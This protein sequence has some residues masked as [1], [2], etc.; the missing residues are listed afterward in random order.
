MQPIVVSSSSSSKT[1]TEEKDL[2]CN[3]CGVYLQRTFIEKSAS[4]GTRSSVQFCWTT[5]TLSTV[6]HISY[7][8]IEAMF[9]QIAVRKDDQDALRF[10]WYKNSGETIY[11]FK[12]LI[13]GATCL[14]SC[15]IY[16]LRKCAIDN[17]HLLPEA[18]KSIM[19]NFHM[20]DFLQTFKTTDEAIK[21]TTC[22]KETLK[23][24]IQLNETLQ[25]RF[26]FSFN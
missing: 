9:M 13:F 21:Q 5:T 3:K 11:K 18:S 10:L 2:S 24:R 20:D 15:A 12:R 14:P 7:W 16:V 22:I 1:Q 17:H 6:C 4:N 26:E 23:R 25:Q 8:N 19:N